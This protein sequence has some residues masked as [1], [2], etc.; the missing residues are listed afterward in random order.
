M[1]ELLIVLVA[2]GP[3]RHRAFQVVCSALQLF[4]LCKALMRV[5]Q[6]SCDDFKI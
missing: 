3:I 6:L 4:L 1:K 5:S 2:L